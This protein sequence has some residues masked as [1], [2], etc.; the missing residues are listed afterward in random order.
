MSISVIARERLSAIVRGKTKQTTGYQ[1][2]RR[3]AKEKHGGN[4][5]FRFPDALIPW[6]T[7]RKESA[8]AVRAALRIG[9]VHH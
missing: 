9:H 1:T 4:N 5:G 7:P 2:A 8:R 3:G 6:Q